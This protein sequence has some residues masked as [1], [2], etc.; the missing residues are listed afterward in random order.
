MISFLFLI[1]CIKIKTF[2]CL[3]SDLKYKIISSLNS[4]LNNDLK[5]LEEIGSLE[6]G[7]R[8]TELGDI[9]SYRFII[10]AICNAAGRAK[11]SN[12][13]PRQLI[14]NSIAAGPYI[15]NCNFDNINDVVLITMSGNNIAANTELIVRDGYKLKIYGIK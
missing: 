14:S 12:M 13:F 1:I 15:V 10:V 8:W 4:D 11:S 6:K 7:I 3:I 5:N 2:A 9:S